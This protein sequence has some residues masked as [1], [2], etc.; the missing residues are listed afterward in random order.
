[1]AAAANSSCTLLNLP[2]SVSASVKGSALSQLTHSEYSI[3]YRP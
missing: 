1:M 2:G 3:T